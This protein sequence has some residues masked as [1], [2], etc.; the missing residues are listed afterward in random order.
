MFGK[1]SRAA[2]GVS[3]L[4]MVG[5]FGVTSASAGAS[6]SGSP[7]TIG[8]ITS[9]TGGAASSYIGAQWGA[10]ARIDALNAAGGVNGH[11]LK[12]DVLDDQTNPAANYTD[13]QEL[14]Q[15]KNA[16]GVIEDSSLAFGA[17]K[18]LNQQGVPVTG[19]AIDGPE[20]GEQPN[21]NMFSVTPPSPTPVDGKYYTYDNTAK[22]LKD[23]GVTKLAGAVYNIQSAIQSMS[24][25][26]QSGVPLGIKNCYENTTVPF[27]DVDFTATALSIKAAGC[28]GVIGVSLLATDIALSSAVKQDGINAKQ[29][30]YTAYDQNLLNQPSSLHT[31]Q[32]A[33][34]TTAV[35]FGDPNAAA[36]TMLANLKK[37]TAFPGGIPSLN[38]VYGYAS[39]DLMIKGLQLAGKNPTR[40]AFITDLRKV[41]SYNVEGLLPS[42]VTFQH[43]GTVG[44]FPATSCEL[45]VQ[46]K[47]HGYVP[48]NGNKPICGK[49]VATS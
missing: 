20:W 13:A 25:L 42:P 46:V 48:Y 34:T 21:T 37:Y 23:I 5:L 44:M 27:G 19:A 35:D 38:V 4:S 43:F 28:N 36:K 1:K 49:R 29:L 16:F 40:N 33:Y 30:Y 22:F 3:L 26:F 9:E 2:V 10:Q 45:I 6:T 8:F 39:A 15:S 24:S 11:K 7:I 14:V 47:G 18:Y 31:M 12:L 41:G 17:A 32:G